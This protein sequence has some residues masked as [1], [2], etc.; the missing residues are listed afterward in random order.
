MWE[1]DNKSQ[2][3]WLISV[4]SENGFNLDYTIHSLIEIDKFI[5]LNYING[6][7]LRSSKFRKHT[8]S[9]YIIC[10][11]LTLYIEKILLKI[12][13]VT[14]ISTYDEIYNQTFYGL[15]IG[16]IEVYTEQKIIKRTQ[17]GFSSSLYP[18]YYELTKQYFNE[19]FRNSFY[20]TKTLKTLKAW[21][22]FW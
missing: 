4:M 8:F 5:Q 14:E 17:N 16:N 6:K 2:I 15:R 22:D 9:D 12:P 3:E 10:H 19:E 18:Y 20:E 21:W 13:E 7:L 11:S 1:K